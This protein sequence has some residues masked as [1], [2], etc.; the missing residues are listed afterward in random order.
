MKHYHVETLVVAEGHTAAGMVA[1]LL[2]CELHKSKFN[3]T[4]L[5]VGGKETWSQEGRTLHRS[6]PLIASTASLFQRNVPALPEGT[7]T[8][9]GLLRSQDVLQIPVD[10]EGKFTL[11][12]KAFG[13][14]PGQ[15]LNQVG[16]RIKSEPFFDETP[17]ELNDKKK[18]KWVFKKAQAAKQ[19]GLE[20]KGNPQM[21]QSLGAMGSILKEHSNAW[22]LPWVFMAQDH[23]VLSEQGMSS[24]LL[25]RFRALGGRIMETHDIQS[26]E[27]SQRSSERSIRHGYDGARIGFDRL[28]WGLGELSLHQKCNQHRK[29]VVPSKENERIPIECL[30][31]ILK[32]N[33]FPRTLPQV[34]LDEQT[35]VWGVFLRRGAYDILVVER[36]HPSSERNLVDIGT[37]MLGLRNNDVISHHSHVRMCDPVLTVDDGDRMESAEEPWDGLIST[38]ECKASLGS[39]CW[40]ATGRM[41]PVLGWEGAWLEAMWIKVNLENALRTGLFR[42][43]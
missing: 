39:N 43:F 20:F 3:V 8:G 7:K 34:M 6:L 23:V 26:V 17:W 21:V 15:L 12:Q 40:V 33:L 11:W 41:A 28:I 10:M 38:L 18:K 5:W 22:W 29:D 4:L 13:S 27:C 14:G 19:V 31:I 36:S 42:L 25:E 16:S 37:S 9:L 30:N 24:Q 35:G 1:L 32:P 2:A